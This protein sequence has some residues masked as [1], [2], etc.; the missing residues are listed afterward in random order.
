MDITSVRIKR[1][2][3]VIDYEN[4]GETHSVT[5]RDN[6]L[7]SFVKA[8][9]GLG[10]LVLDILHLP[11]EYQHGMKPTGLT[12]VGKQG[13]QLVSIVAQKELTDCNSPFNISTPLRFLSVPEEEGSYSPPLSDK[14]VALVESVI[15]EAKKY[16]KG[17]RAQGQLPLDDMKNG[18]EDD[19]PAEPSEGDEMDFDPKKG[20]AP[21]S[22]PAPTPAKK[23]R[24]PRK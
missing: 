20:G 22:E 9:D 11:T 8:V 16:V 5:S 4:E 12:V 10:S 21:A 3:V 2:A 19:A 13:T 18:D 1:R 24:K 14:Q 6:P 17:D 15:K 7:P 23:P